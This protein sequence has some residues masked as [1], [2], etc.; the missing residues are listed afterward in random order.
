MT[1]S[2]A[3]ENGWENLI[4]LMPL[5]ATHYH[6]MRERLAKDGI[7]YP[8]F[9]PRV[10]AYVDYWQNGTLVNYAVRDDEGRAVGYANVYVTR[11][12]HN[13][14]LIAQEDTI[15]ILKAHRN[16]IGRKLVKFILS[17]L[18]ERGVKRSNITAMTDLRVAKI[19]ERMGFK[20]MATAMTYIFK[21]EADFK[22][23]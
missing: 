14:E 13:S 19:W 20:P 10:D 8:P 23:L 5:Y 12:M 16:G 3:V 6:E 18:R 2:I 4:E 17:D 15:F 7:E 21:E 1:Y 11:D 9:K 22:T